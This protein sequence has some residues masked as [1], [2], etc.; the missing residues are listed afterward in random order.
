MPLG[1][2]AFRMTIKAIARTCLGDVFDDNAE[3]EKLSSCYHACW[4]EMEAS[5]GCVDWYSVFHLKILFICIT[6]II[7]IVII[8][9]LLYMHW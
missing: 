4:R 8:P 2:V 5:T 3:V 6:I 1:A 7:I 9:S